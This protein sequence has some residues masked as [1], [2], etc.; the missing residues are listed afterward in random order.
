MGEWRSSQRGPL[1]LGRNSGQ[2]RMGEAGTE[3][4]TADLAAAALGGCCTALTKA[5]S[6][7]ASRGGL[8][9]GPAPPGRTRPQTPP[10]L[11]WG[12]TYTGA[13]HVLLLNPGQEGV[14]RASKG[15]PKQ[16]PNS[17]ACSEHLLHTRARLPPSC[18]TSCPSTL[19]SELRPDQNPTWFCNIP[20]PVCGRLSSS[21]S[22]ALEHSLPRSFAW[23]PPTNHS[24][25]GPHVSSLERPS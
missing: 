6:S 5:F 7:R 8:P 15:S 10:T 21:P 18:L 12:L 25:P 19:A 22:F 23:C 9:G 4:Q 17:Q 1:S 2:R 3:G 14:G 11:G 13:L 24:H 20:S 16:G